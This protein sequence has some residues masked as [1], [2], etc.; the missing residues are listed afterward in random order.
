MMAA[1]MMAAD[2]AVLKI[3][4]GTDSREFVTYGFISFLISKRIFVLAVACNGNRKSYCVQLSTFP[5]LH[6]YPSLSI[7]FVES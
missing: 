7:P 1:L 5:P 6:T 4:L 3:K 2:D